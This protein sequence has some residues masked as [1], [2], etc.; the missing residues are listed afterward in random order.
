M[1]IKAQKSSELAADVPQRGICSVAAR[2]CWHVCVRWQKKREAKHDL[3]GKK[4]PKIQKR[5]VYS[6]IINVTAFIK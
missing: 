2:M 6:G 4:M 1:Q 3:E 5:G